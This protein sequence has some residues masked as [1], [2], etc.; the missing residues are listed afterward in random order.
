MTESSLPT[1]SVCVLNWNSRD[2]LAD[3]L[4]GVYAQAYPAA[5]VLVVDNGSTDGSVGFLRRR[6]PQLAI[7]ETGGNLGYA[8]GNNIALRKPAADIV[9]LLNPDVVL[10]PGCLAAIAQ[11]MAGDP[12]IGIAGC[13]LWY[14]GGKVIQHAGGYITHPRAIP[15]HYGIGEPDEGQH[16]VVR[17]VEYVIGA[18]VAIRRELLERIGVLDEGFFLFFEDVDLCTRALKADYR[19]VYLPQATAIHV[20]SATTAK[21]SF[22]YLQRMHIGRWRYLLK[23]FPETELLSETLPAE[24][25]WLEQTAESERQA[26]SLAYLAIMRGL[27]GIWS[28]R[29][30]EGAG[31][32]SPDVQETLQSSLAALRAR[33]TATLL[34]SPARQRLAAAATLEEMPFRS[35][36]PL[37]GPLIAWVR[38][39]W[40]NVASRWYLGHLMAQQNEFNR[41]AVAQLEGYEVELRELME[42]LEEQVVLTTEM[43]MRVQE[44]QALLADL[45]RQ[46][47]AFPPKHPATH[48]KN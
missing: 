19:V 18:A 14:P 41:L 43:Q 42:L 16:D 31:A 44:L 38:T 5:R 46:G 32:M 33:A 6:F 7:H 8:G 1:I 37:L 48:I 24:M 15:G 13:K 47:A 11:A 23:H 34:E 20:E 28:A 36:V 35:N 25:A 27:P 10:S 26:A 9:F 12:T 22:A 21:G 4:D 40:N 45:N 17:D 29:E 30:R 3:C 2:Y 39:A